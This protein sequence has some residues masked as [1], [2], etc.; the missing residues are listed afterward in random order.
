MR[1]TE[2]ILGM[3]RERGTKGLHLERVYRLLFNRQLYLRAY[4]RLAPNKGAMTAG[5]TP[6]TV[7]GMCVAKIDAIIDDLRHERYRWTP[8]RRTYIPKKNGKLRPLGIPTW[9]DK[10]LQEVIRSILEAYYE[11]QFSPHSHGFR[12]GRGCHTALGEINRNWSG[13]TWFIEGDIKGCFD[14]I[15]HQVLLSTLAEKIHDNRFLRLLANLLKAGYLEDWRYGQTLSGTPQGVVISPILANIYLDRLDKFVAGVLAPAYNRGAKRQLNRDWLRVYGKAQYLARTGRRHEAKVMRRQAQ[16]LPCFDVADSGF[17]R[18]RFIRYADDFLLGFSGPRSEA[19]EIKRQLGEF[20]RDHLRLEL[21]AAKTLITSARAEA[22]H[23]LGYEIVVLQD[24]DK[25]THG[26]RAINGNVGLRV[27][28][29]VIKAKCQTYQKRGKPVHR[30]QL[31]QASDYT[32]LAQYQTEFRGLAQYYQLAYNVCHLNRLKWVMEQSLTKTLAA[33][34]KLSVQK[35]YARY[36]TVLQTANGPRKGLQVVV[37]RPGKRALVAQWGGISL[38]R[39][40][41]AVLDDQPPSVYNGRTELLER[42]LADT[43]ELC[44]SSAN[45]E[46]HH[47]RALKD[48]ERRGRAARPEWARLM[49]TRHRKTLVVCRPCH[50]DIHAGRLDGREVVE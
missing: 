32:I 6:E 15:D 5:A 49:A 40:K 46:V 19:E 26:R 28:A 31:L 10:L 36:G 20:L 1:E 2:T 18:L 22:A 39:R 12:A 29:E 44:G 16:T 38:R 11:P 8:V 48:L 17:R 21:S 9:S 14:N 37:E 41:Q 35:V 45:V 43:C 27:P 4:G 47:V 13:T 23:F 33:K 42:L 24:N 3:I 25:L 30:P 34:L 7:D 50:R